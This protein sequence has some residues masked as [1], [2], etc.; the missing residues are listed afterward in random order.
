MRVSIG[1]VRLFVEVLGR[2]PGAHRR[3]EREATA[4]P[5]R[6]AR[7]SRAR[8]DNPASVADPARELRSSRG[9]RSPRPRSQRSRCRHRLEPV[10]LGRRR[11]P[12][13]HDA[14]HRAPG[15]ARHV[16][17]RLRR[18][19]IR[20]DLSRPACRPRAGEHD[21]TTPA[22]MQSSPVRGNSEAKRPRLR[23]A[24]LIDNPDIEPSNEDQQRMRSLY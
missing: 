8:R 12:A 5:D 14:R 11:A 4:H 18:P 10:I 16:V 22:A 15:V 20:R 1:S 2:Q 7:R 23:F 9:P 3:P 13:L 17:R 21:A 19:A 6:A 24:A